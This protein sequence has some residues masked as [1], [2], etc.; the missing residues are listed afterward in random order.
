[1]LVIGIP[2]ER[3]GVLS[4]DHLHSFHETEREALKA[5]EI[6]DARFGHRPDHDIL[7]VSSLSERCPRC[8]RS[9]LA[10]IR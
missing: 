6:N 1:M 9:M 5:L 8:H 10:L 2:D 3:F 7:V 4:D